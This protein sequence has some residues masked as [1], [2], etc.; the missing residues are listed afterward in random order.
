MSH[1]ENDTVNFESVH[2]KEIEKLVEQISKLTSQHPDDITSD[3]KK[4]LV[5][6]R[7][8]VNKTASYTHKTTEKSLKDLLLSMPNVG[9]DSDFSRIADRGR[10]I[11]L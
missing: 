9:E 6:L 4:F 8:K 7:N 5:R 10:D 2:A 11:S 3:V 1:T